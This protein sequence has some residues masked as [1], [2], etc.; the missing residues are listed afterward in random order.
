MG[1]KSFNAILGF[2]SHRQ[3]QHFTLT[4]GSW[5]SDYPVT[6]LNNSEYAKVAQS[7]DLNAASLEV[8]GTS[9]VPRQLGAIHI[10]AH[11]GTLQG[12]FQLEGFSDTARSDKIYDSGSLLLWPS[13]YDYNRSIYSPNFMTG[14]YSAAEIE[15]QIPGR[16]LLIPTAPAV[17]AFRLTFS[18]PDNP[19]GRFRVGMLETCEAYQLPVN[20]NYGSQFGYQFYSEIEQLEGGLIRADKKAPSYVFDGFVPHLPINE[21]RNKVMELFRQHQSIDPVLWIPVPE[22]PRTWLRESKM[23]R[24]VRPGLFGHSST[25][26]AGVP[27]TLEEFRG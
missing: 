26:R 23:V 2:T 10:G 20:Y 1:V 4:G 18:D 17:R 14:Q 25:G 11:N 13:V 3:R 24:L 27:L 6:N 12:R 9:T 8:I 16:T 21:V 15:G 19:A 22:D 5:D 7:D